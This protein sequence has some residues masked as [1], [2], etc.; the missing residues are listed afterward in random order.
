MK[1]NRKVTKMAISLF[2][3][4]MLIVLLFFF[5]QKFNVENDANNK[6]KDTLN[7]EELKNKELE[8][9]SEKTSANNPETLPDKSAENGTSTDNKEQE[10]VKATNAISNEQGIA[11]FVKD[12]SFGSTA[13]LLIDSGKVN[14]SYEYYQFFLGDKQ[15]SNI[16][17]ITKTETTI[18]PAQKAGSEVVLNLLDKDKKVLKKLNVILNE[19][20]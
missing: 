11:A 9:D 2:A 13:E 7:S 18:F 8:K 1:N 12:A 3:V 19:K 4:I 14:N 10:S 20:K 17:G 15:I 5:L 6:N 16:E